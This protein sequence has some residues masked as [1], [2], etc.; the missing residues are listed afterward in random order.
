[1]TR[2]RKVRSLLYDYLV[3]GLDE[4]ESRLVRDHLD[5]CA[6]CSRDADDL[7]ALLAAFPPPSGS[8]AGDLPQ[9]YWDEFVAGVERKLP[10]DSVPRRA[11]AAERAAGALRL[12]P[13]AVIDAFT[14]RRPVP[15][16]AMAASGVAVILLVLLMAGREG[17]RPDSPADGA[18][19]ASG[20]IPSDVTPAEG[21]VVTERDSVTDFDR[22]VGQYFRRS[23]TLL[24]GMANARPGEGDVVDLD[25][26]KTV[27]RSLLAEARYLRYGPVD[28]RSWRL[29]EDLDEIMIELANMDSHTGES[30]VGM[31]RDGI[32]NRNLLFKL[33]MRETQSNRT[34]VQQAV[35]YK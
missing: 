31:L 27:S 2:H 33:R 35:Y 8:P 7:R 23:K 12:I 22:R 5:R 32:R 24:V 11:G 4:G 25:A 17:G 20:E 15:L 28:P 6:K 29:M 14:F 9:S 3:S 16:A 19:M 21:A 10:E 1:M 13:S 18:G 34:P 30:S 26:E